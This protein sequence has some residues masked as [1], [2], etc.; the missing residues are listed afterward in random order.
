MLLSHKSL[1]PFSSECDSE[2]DDEFLPLVT[3]ANLQVLSRVGETGDHSPTPTSILSDG[4][5]GTMMISSFVT[6]V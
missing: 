5:N 2:I 1:F 6:P 3:E 4:Q